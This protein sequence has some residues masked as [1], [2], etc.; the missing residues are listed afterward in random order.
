MYSIFNTYPEELLFRIIQQQWEIDPSILK[1]TNSDLENFQKPQWHSH[2]SREFYQTS[3]SRAY[4]IHLDKQG[5]HRLTISLLIYFFQQRTSI[6]VYIYISPVRIRIRSESVPR[7]HSDINL[8]YISREGLWSKAWEKR[9]WHRHR[10]PTFLRSPDLSRGSFPIFPILG[11]QM[12]SR[13]SILFLF[14]SSSSST[15]TTLLPRL[16]IYRAANVA[17]QQQQLRWWTVLLLESRRFTAWEKESEREKKTAT[18]T[19]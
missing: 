3:F 18:S 10:Y 4:K 9:Q 15:T 13:R 16:E 11:A 7:T 14:S 2:Y 19:L 6:A 12:I 8:I 17:Q 1:R 5:D